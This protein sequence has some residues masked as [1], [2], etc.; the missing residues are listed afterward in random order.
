VTTTRREL[1]TLLASAA[2]E[3]PG[4]VWG[5]QRGKLRTIGFLGTATPSSWGLWTGAAG[6]RWRVEFRRGLPARRLACR[7]PQARN[8]AEGADHHRAPHPQGRG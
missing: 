1:I 2:V 3:W 5:Q 4:A 6:G 7:P 8:R